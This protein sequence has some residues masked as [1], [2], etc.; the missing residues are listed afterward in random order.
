[1]KKWMKTKNNLLTATHSGGFFTL[2]YRVLECPSVKFD[3]IKL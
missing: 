2:E 1:M 3:T